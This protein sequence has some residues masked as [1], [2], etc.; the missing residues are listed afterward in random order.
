MSSEPRFDGRTQKKHLRSS[1]NGPTDFPQLRN[2]TVHDEDSTSY[3]L[4][5]I[6][7]GVGRV[8]IRNTLLPCFPQMRYFILGTVSKSTRT[9]SCVCLVAM[10]NIDIGERQMRSTCLHIGVTGYSTC[11]TPIRPDTFPIL[12][13]QK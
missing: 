10:A 5:L 9:R 3:A 2:E 4:E 11:R 6:C 1:R 12:L 13:L 8:P 7:A